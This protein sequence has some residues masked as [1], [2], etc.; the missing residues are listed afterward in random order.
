MSDYHHR[1]HFLATQLSKAE[2]FVPLM[3]QLS[4]P[5][6]QH[7]LSMLPTPPA[8]PLPTSESWTSW[9]TLPCPGQCLSA[10]DSREPWRLAQVSNWRD[11]KAGQCCCSAHRGGG[12]NHH[13]AP[14]PAALDCRCQGQRH[15]V[16]QPSP[17]YIYI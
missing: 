1:P 2:I 7:L 14:L 16:K 11:Q 5:C 6:K 3:L 13:S 17:Q 9:T 8:M 12:D 10:T 4:I 15:P